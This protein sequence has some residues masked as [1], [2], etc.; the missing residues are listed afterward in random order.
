MATQQIELRG[1]NILDINPLPGEHAYK[2]D[3]IPGKAGKKY[4]VFTYQKV[5][6]TVASD[7]QFCTLIDSGKLFRVVL[8]ETQE[9]ETRRFALLSANS[10][11]ACTNMAKGE[12][13]LNHIAKADYAPEKVDADLLNAIS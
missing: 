6:F 3:T 13:L 7:D 5:A 10:L 11:D 8:D 2:A 12:A 1:M 4:R 9:G